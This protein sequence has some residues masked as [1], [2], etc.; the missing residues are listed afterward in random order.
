[1]CK[2][3]NGFYLLIGSLC[4]NTIRSHF[5]KFNHHDLALVRDGQSNEN[6][7]VNPNTTEST[8]GSECSGPELV[9]EKVIHGKTTEK[10][11]LNSN[12]MSD[13]GYSA[14]ELM[15]SIF[16]AN[17]YGLIQSKSG[18]ELI[19]EKV[20]NRHGGEKSGVNPNTVE[21]MANSEYSRPKEILN[22]RTGRVGVT[23]SQSPA[24]YKCNFC[25]EGFAKKESVGE[26]ARKA[27]F[28]TT[29]LSDKVTFEPGF[30]EALGYLETAENSDLNPN[31]N[32]SMSVEDATLEPMENVVTSFDERIKG[33]G[34]GHRQRKKIR[35]DKSLQFE[36]RTNQNEMI[37]D[38]KQEDVEIIEEM[39]KT[40]PEKSGL[41]PSILESMSGSG[42]TGPELVV[43]KVLNKRTTENGG[44]EYLIKWKDFS[45]QD[46]TWEPREN[47]NC[48]TLIAAFTKSNAKQFSLNS[49]RFKCDR[50]NKYFESQKSFCKHT[51]KKHVGNA[52]KSSLN[53]PKRVIKKVSEELMPFKCAFCN[54][55][56][57]RLFKKH[58]HM[59]WCMREEKEKARTER[60]E[61][62]SNN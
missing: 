36:P 18:P 34:K 9:A 16:D 51:R 22:M 12:S 56:F 7:G 35:L 29:N 28:D 60:K 14:P 30:F 62:K 50:C 2:K 59:T 25:H 24:V 3:N 49:E 47:L 44:I 1:M 15:C 58:F 10:S 38:G 45:D 8:S 61:K 11:G 20:I 52:I 19:I 31:T 54:R 57:S 5:A 6:F 42:Y 4:D 21:S 23:D 33:R 43:E 53:Q 13:S 32:Q 40:S 37:D 26:H 48:E 17:K 41:N 27:H 55:G 46:A 39:N